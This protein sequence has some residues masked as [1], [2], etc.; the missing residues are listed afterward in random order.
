ME[1][2][3][4]P[5][6]TVS[7]TSNQQPTT[8]SFDMKDLYIPIAIVVA[9]ACVGAGLFFGGTSK[10]A[11]VAATAGQNENII[12]TLVEKAGVKMN[13]VEACMNNGETKALVQAD[14]DN[15]VATGGRGTPWSI[16]IG[17]TGK[18][19]PVNGAVPKAAVQQVIDLARAE[20]DYEVADDSINTDAV[21]PV[22]ADDHII[23]SLDNPIKIVEYSDFDCPFCTRMHETLVEI[24]AENSDV[25]W[26]YRHFP[27]DSLH[28]N[29]RTIA[30]IS[31]CVAQEGGNDAFWTFADGYFTR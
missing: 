16:V 3:Q 11:P 1:E 31:E 15:A 4:Q 5:E 25:S 27:L 30:N 29:A 20:A 18:T 19:Y 14:A 17:P 22:T 9:G 8:T 10:A 23:G 21:L 12:E 2:Q 26:V 28:P 7:T 6:T 13:A 24:V